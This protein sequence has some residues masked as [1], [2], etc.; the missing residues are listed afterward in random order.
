MILRNIVN[1]VRHDYGI[2]VMP[3]NN[4]YFLKVFTFRNHNL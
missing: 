3:K 1:F 4:F 2:V